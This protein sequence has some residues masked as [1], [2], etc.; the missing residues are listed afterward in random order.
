MYGLF[1]K[2]TEFI[3]K[4]PLVV[5][6]KYRKYA[7]DMTIAE[8]KITVTAVAGPLFMLDLPQ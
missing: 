1:V 4:L 3:L 8:I 7:P 2:V 6:L 5:G